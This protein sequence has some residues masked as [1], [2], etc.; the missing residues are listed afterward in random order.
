MGDFIVR[1]NQSIWINSNFNRLI[2]IRVVKKIK[3][4]ILVDVDDCSIVRSGKQ[5]EKKKLISVTL[6]CVMN[7]ML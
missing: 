2:I 6:L 4:R 5:M 7:H 3:L 1:N